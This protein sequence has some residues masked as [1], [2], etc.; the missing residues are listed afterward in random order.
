VITKKKLGRPSDYKPE[1]CNQLINFMA[2]GYSFEAF[3]GYIGKHKDVL[4]NWAKKN[5]DF[6]D[7]KKIAFARCQYFWE[8]KGMEGMQKGRDFN[9]T[10]WIF[11]MKNRFFWR[12]RTEVSTENEAF[13]IDIS[14]NHDNKLEDP[15]GT[16][17]HDVSN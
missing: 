10:V 3:A 7:A 16:V 8:R 13:K 17:L 9:A 14:V 5:P 1:Y 15:R 4:Y 11:N 6:N 2:E 12:D